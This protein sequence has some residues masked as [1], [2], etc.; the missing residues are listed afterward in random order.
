MSKVIYTVRN[1]N[2]L[3]TITTFLDQPVEAATDSDGYRMNV[4]TDLVQTTLA[5]NDQ[6]TEDQIYVTSEFYTDSDS[7]RIWR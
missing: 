4:I 5:A 1:K 6:L 3:R 2:N 7:H